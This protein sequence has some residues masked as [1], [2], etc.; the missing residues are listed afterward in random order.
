MERIGLAPGTEL[1]G[2][3]VLG[4]LG[5]GGMG[6]VYRALDGDGATV[7]LKLVHPHLTDGPARDRLTRE[8]A[9]LQR[10][11]HP[12]VARVLDAEIDS[13]EA[14]VVTELVDGP[15]LAEHVEAAGPLPADALADLAEQLRVAL[16]AVHGAGVLHRD[17][18]PTNVLVSERGPVLIDFGIA[19]AAE[20]ARVTSAG[21]VAGTPGYLSPAL[22]AGQEPSTA[23]DWWGWACVLAFAATGR[24]PFGVRPLAA[25]LARVRTG[26]VDL[27]DV[28]PRVAEVLRAALA[29][30]AATRPA[31][32]ATVAGLRRAAELD[33][34]TVVAT[35]AA[36]PADAGIGAQ[37]PAATAV[38]GAD[39]PGGTKVLPVD[40]HAAGAGPV[41]PLPPAT[42]VV[43]AADADRDQSDWD[44][45]GLDDADEDE[46]DEA[47]DEDGPDEDVD[48]A[49][50]PSP[51]RRTGTVLAVGAALAAAGAAW[52]GVALLVAVVLAVVVRSVGLDVDAMH[53]RRLR[54]GARGGDAARAVAGWP[55]YLLR[56]VLGVLPAALVAAS[57]VVVVGG[58]GWWLVDT[59]R[60]T[61]APPAPGESAGDLA[62]NAAWVVPA[63]LAVALAV[64]LVLVWF[65]PMSRATRRGAR[66]TL[67]A[68]APGRAGAATAVLVAL[69]GAAVLG[70]LVVLGQPVTWWP[71]PGPPDLR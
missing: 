26:E 20:D 17:L 32:E 6:A 21:Q 19:Q 38:L 56:A 22:L 24:P 30:D 39:A 65:G 57:A 68:V 61:V 40:P 29:V 64:G 4:P 62:G 10:V 69:A 45:D 28:D 35:T 54:R 37:E 58:V 51:R 5:Q 7:A 67:A 70:T 8:V 59:G 12:G 50:L 3:R 15:T 36:G 55:W 31:P 23:D 47:Y 49:D 46:G 11:R 16:S 60:V 71:L 1:G 66:W 18:T 48:E 25:V 44:D 63:L 33:G 41:L 53:A 52:P 9:A 2:Y 42:V 27:D 43:A 34:A 13:A 14:F